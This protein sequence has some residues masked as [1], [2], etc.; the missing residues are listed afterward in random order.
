MGVS[1]GKTAAP[2]LL[3]ALGQNSGEGQL[4]SMDV[5]DGVLAL[6]HRSGSGS[7][8]LKCTKLKITEVLTYEY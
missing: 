3:I 2:E 4:P 7:Y 5:Q 6:C 1:G 8:H